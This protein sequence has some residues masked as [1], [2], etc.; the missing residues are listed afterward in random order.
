MRRMLA[1][2]RVAA[3]ALAAVLALAPGCSRAR[4]RPSAPRPARRLL[5]PA[6]EGLVA[7]ALRPFVCNLLAANP[8]PVDAAAARPTGVFV[9]VVTRKY[10][11]TGQR[12]EAGAT[13]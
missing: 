12:L 4:E 8:P 7:P 10:V 13:L 3:L 2:H 11:L 6:R 5:Y 9:R 1:R